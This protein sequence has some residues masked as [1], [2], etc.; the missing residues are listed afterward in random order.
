MELVTQEK[1]KGRREKIEYKQESLF[2][3]L[4]LTK[5]QDG[6]LTVEEL[7][8]QQNKEMD[9]PNKPSLLITNGFPTLLLIFHPQ[10]QADYRFQIEPA[11]AGE[12][13]LTGIRFEHIPGM[14]STCA[15][16]LRD[17]IYPLELQGTAWVDNETGA[18]QK[19]D[20]GLIAPMKDINI[21]AFDVEV[22]YKPQ[23]FQSEHE[24]KW[25][26][27]SAVINIQTAL[28]HWR[29]IHLFSQYKRFTVES[30]ETTSH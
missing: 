22:T 3:Y 17:R 11:R 28:Q 15:L 13:N 1:I 24:A 27:S 14:P 19:I 21:K 30:S 8:L 2:D 23:L 10:Y 29:N 7:R 20:A 6:S 5:D 16:M 26:P 25:L 12:G 18:I 9:K 4:A